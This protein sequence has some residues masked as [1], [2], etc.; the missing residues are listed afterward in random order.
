MLLIP[1]RL[2]ETPFVHVLFHGLDCSILGKKLTEHVYERESYLVRHAISIVLKGK[3][4]IRGENG[5]KLDIEAGQ[6]GFIPKGLY[7]VTDLL[8]EDGE[9]TSW[10]IYLD[11]GYFERLRSIAGAIPANEAS[12]PCIAMPA[13]MRQFFETLE[14]AAHNLKGAG[15]MYFD[16]KIR[17]FFGILL[18]EHGEAWLSGLFAWYLK[19]PDVNLQ[20]FMEAHFD[21]PFSINDFAF[22]TGLSSSTFN[23]TFK[24]KFGTSP[25]KWLIEKRLAR[26]SELLSQGQY[27]VADVAQQV[28]FNHTSHFI[29]SF[30]KQFGHTPGEHPRTHNGF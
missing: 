16:G 19:K 9:F 13:I 4:V 2:L 22:L 21:K 30:K 17:E 12:S 3:Q 15:E 26:A 11:V 6:I 24:L 25:R 28:G 29:Q 8:A 5:L 1:N 7:T 14:D 23:R 27:N 20:A 10:H 18:A